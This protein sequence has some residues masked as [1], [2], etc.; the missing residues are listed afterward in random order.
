M[1]TETP[2]MRLRR[3]RWRDPRLAIGILLVIVS[4]LLGSLLAAR[5]SQ[6][7]TVLAAREA[8]VPGD[9]LTREDLTTVDVRLGDAASGY[10]TSLDQIPEGAV[11]V[12]AV[13][14]GELLAVSAIGQPADVSLRPLVIAVDAAVAESVVP[15]GSVELWRTRE[16]ADGEDPTAELLVEKAV[17]RRVDEGSSLGM[18][19]MSVE[20]LVPQEFLAAVLEALAAGE[21]LDVIGI[22]G[23]DGVRS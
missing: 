13:H 16:G 2:V 22:P 10:V 15:G 12:S 23:A 9:V 8:I 21:R 11:A 7:V 18:R 14:P 3:P 17:V 1:A 4:V 6:T 19:A 5:L 20:V